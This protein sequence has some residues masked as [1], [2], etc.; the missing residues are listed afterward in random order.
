[1]ASA[2]AVGV[3]GVM[4]LLVGCAPGSTDPTNTEAP[5]D[6]AAAEQISEEFLQVTEPH[7]LTGGTLLEGPTF[8]E[9]GSLFMV[10]V[11]A[12]AGEAK[13]ARESM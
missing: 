12:P 5:S 8:H 11:M 7:E 3:V 1:V 13:G 9:D 10:D 2:T 6:G 4:T